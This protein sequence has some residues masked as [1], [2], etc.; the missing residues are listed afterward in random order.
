MAK[1][2][3]VLES[4]IDDFKEELKNLRLKSIHKACNHT[5]GNPYSGFNRWHLSMMANKKGYPTARYATYKQISAAGGQVKKGERGFPVFFWSHLYK[6]DGDITVS[7]SG[8]TEALKKAQKK[9]PFLTIGSLKDKK[10]FMKHF[11]VFNIAQAEGIEFTYEDSEPLT[12]EALCKSASTS[13][14]LPSSV[15]YYEGES[16]TLFLDSELDVDT[17]LPSLIESTSHESRLNRD[18]EY[19]QENLVDHIGA[20]FL[21]ESLNA[22]EVLLKEETVERWLEALD[23]NPMFLYK[24]AGLAEKAAKFLIEN[25]D[26]SEKAAAA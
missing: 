12:I 24:S 11:T 22:N 23:A 2:Q 3:D 20:A 13:N 16:D 1:T 15:S 6:F 4:I 7:A 18:V 5:T 25:A 19:L 17:T 9:N 8:E 10:M 21:A 26:T 14:M